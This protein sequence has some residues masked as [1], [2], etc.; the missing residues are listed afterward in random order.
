MGLLPYLHHEKTRYGEKRERIDGPGGPCVPGGN[1][2][3][4]GGLIAAMCYREINLM[5]LV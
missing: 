4:K 2:P 1:G 3:G 5:T